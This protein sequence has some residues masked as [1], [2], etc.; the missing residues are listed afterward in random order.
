M[1]IGSIWERG[2]GWE[3]WKANILDQVAREGSSR[4]QVG[5]KM[6]RTGRGYIVVREVFRRDLVARPLAV[7]GHET[8]A[9]DKQGPSEWHMKSNATSA[10][11]YGDIVYEGKT[12]LMLWTE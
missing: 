5:M 4:D 12:S 7:I 1:L 8:N 6:E 11:R 3:F 10:L 9:C 2:D